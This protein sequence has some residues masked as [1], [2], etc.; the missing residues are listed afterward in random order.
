MKALITRK[1]GIKMFFLFYIWYLYSIHAVRNIDVAST[2]KRA[3]FSININ[4]RNDKAS[5]RKILQPLW[6]DR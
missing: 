3:E 4:T 5:N 1:H 6:S 2:A